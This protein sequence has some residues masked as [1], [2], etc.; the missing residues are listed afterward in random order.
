MGKR[1]S[2]HGIGV[3]CALSIELD[4]IKHSRNCWKWRFQTTH[5]QENKYGDIPMYHAYD[6]VSKQ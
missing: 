4:N 2:I 6:Q 3:S 5:Y 1:V